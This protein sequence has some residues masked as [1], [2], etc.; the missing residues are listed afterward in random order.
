VHVDYDNDDDCKESS[1]ESVV[2]IQ[3]QNGAGS[4]HDIHMPHILGF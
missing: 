2:I 4:I 3:D 1:L